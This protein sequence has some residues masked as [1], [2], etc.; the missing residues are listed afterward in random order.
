[1]YYIY[2]CLLCTA[3]L[4]VSGF[5]IVTLDWGSLHIRSSSL[6]YLL[7]Y[8]WAHFEWPKISSTIFYA[9]KETN[10]RTPSENIYKNINF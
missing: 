3:H 1:M 8:Y 7:V 9:P 2:M 4:I 10:F 5:I 6:Y